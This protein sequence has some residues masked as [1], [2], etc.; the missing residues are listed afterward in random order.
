MKRNCNGCR[1][2]V[3][4]SNGGFYCSLG[5]KI[6]SINKFD[7]TVGAKPTEECPKPKTYEKYLNL[8]EGTR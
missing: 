4:N 2:L 1:A 3:D 6:Q 5:Y 7:S 8:R